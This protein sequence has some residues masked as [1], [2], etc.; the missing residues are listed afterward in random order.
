MLFHCVYLGH[1]NGFNNLNDI[2]YNNSGDDDDGS[3]TTAVQQQRY[4]NINYNNISSNN[5]INVDVETLY[6]PMILHRRISYI[7]VEVGVKVGIAVDAVGGLV[8]E[9]YIK[10]SHCNSMTA[11]YHV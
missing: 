9:R 2:N 7:G 3:T 6:P 5:N 4:N 10:Q 1:N 8:N 11:C